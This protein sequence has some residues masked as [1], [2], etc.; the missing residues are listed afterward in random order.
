VDLTSFI[1]GKFL[2]VHIFV[3]RRFEVRLDDSAP[4]GECWK[5]LLK[6]L[7]CKVEDL[8]TSTPFRDLILATN[9]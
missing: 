3:A 4:S 2:V 6:R 7:S 8:T 1:L 9:L 5:Y